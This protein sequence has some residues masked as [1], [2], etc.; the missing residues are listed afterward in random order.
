[1]LK[2]KEVSKI[3]GDGIKAL[4]EADIEIKEGEIVVILGPSGAGKSTLLRCINRLIEPTKGKIFLNGEEITL[5]LSYC[6]RQGRYAYASWLGRYS[7]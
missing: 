6:K 2:L 3:Y 7:F 1:M 5:V 4:S